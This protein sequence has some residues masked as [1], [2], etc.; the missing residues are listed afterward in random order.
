M[1]KHW[2]VFHFVLSLLPSSRF[3]LPV[4]DEKFKLISVQNKKL[5]L[6]DNL[7][8]K[9][10]ILFTQT[11]YTMFWFSATVFS[12]TGNFHFK[13]GVIHTTKQPEKFWLCGWFSNYLSPLCQKNIILTDKQLIILQWQTFDLPTKTIKSKPSNSPAHHYIK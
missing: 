10:R 6:T 12:T 1:N 7:F 8:I 11:L 9:V 3:S 2:S 5:F 13:P 4:S